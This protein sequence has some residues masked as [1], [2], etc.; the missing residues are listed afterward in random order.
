MNDLEIGRLKFMLKVISIVTLLSIG[1]ISEEEALKNDTF[2]HFLKEE[3]GIDAKDK[4]NTL[5]KR[6]K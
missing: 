5:E 3:F 2:K 1:F 6:G 4:M